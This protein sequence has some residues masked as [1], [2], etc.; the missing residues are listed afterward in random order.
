MEADARRAAPSPK[1]SQRR[2][3]GMERRRGFALRHIQREKPTSE[4]REALNAR[5]TQ[6]R[7]ISE[8]HEL[9]V[10]FDYVMLAN[11]WERCTSFRFGIRVDMRSTH[12]VVTRSGESGIERREGHALGIEH[13]VKG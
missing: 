12:C 11:D 5:L 3:R 10:H 4:A 1:K 7:G 13:N 8:N 9:V 6:N 2:R